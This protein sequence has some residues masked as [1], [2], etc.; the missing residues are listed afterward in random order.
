MQWLLIEDKAKDKILNSNMDWNLTLVEPKHPALHTKADI[1]PFSIDVD[2]SVRES[3]MIKL[4][5]DQF[6]IGLAAPQIGESIKFF[7]M[8]FDNNGPD[9]GIFNPEILEYSDETVSMEEGCLTFPALFFMVTRPTKIKVKFQTSNK[10][11]VEDW[12]DGRDARCFQHEFE[13]LQGVI[14]LEHASELKLQRA[15]KK[16]EKYIKQA[17]AY[18]NSQNV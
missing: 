6:G 5:H 17:I 13:H 12:L 9:I 3:E 14:Y 15:M 10:E 4:M 11:F 1:D 8:N 18:N 7:V 16:R 2:W